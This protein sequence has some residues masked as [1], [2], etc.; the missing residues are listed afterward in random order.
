MIIYAGYKNNSELVYIGMTKNFTQRVKDHKYHTKKTN[1]IFG[2]AITNFTDLS[3][4][5]KTVDTKQRGCFMSKSGL[6]RWF[7]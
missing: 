5:L 2:K 6:K 4:C 1:Y 3:N 7:R